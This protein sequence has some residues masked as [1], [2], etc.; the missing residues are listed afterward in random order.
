MSQLNLWTLQVELTA[1]ELC[2]AQLAMNEQMQRLIESAEIELMKVTVSF[3]N[4]LDIRAAE[5]T[6]PDEVLKQDIQHLMIQ[7]HQKMVE[8]DT[9]VATISF[10]VWIVTETE[11]ANTKN[12]KLKTV[13]IFNF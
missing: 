6:E 1:Q 2:G 11:K 7:V 8:V 5:K 12:Q 3:R 13:M 10:S 9:A 4:G